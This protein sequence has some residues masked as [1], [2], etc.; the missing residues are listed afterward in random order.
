MILAKE[1]EFINEEG[2]TLHVDKTKVTII[3]IIMMKQQ[4]F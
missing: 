4:D 3:Y 1:L 2:G